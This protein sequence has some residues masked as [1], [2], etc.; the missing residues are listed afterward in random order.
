M[1]GEA[2]FG[3]N[4]AGFQGG[5][6]QGFNPDFAYLDGARLIAGGRER[7]ARAAVGRTRRHASHVERPV[8]AYASFG[9]DDHETKT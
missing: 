7:S 9:L 5:V 1:S 4:L 6:F 8:D 3:R 2:F